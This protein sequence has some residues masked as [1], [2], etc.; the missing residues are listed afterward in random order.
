MLIP[1]TL[2]LKIGWIMFLNIF[3]GIYGS[4]RPGFIEGYKALKNA[5][6]PW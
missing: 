4:N 2:N 3:D 6:Q 1:I 5:I